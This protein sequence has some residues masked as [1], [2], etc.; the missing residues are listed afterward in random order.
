MVQQIEDDL[1]NEF[2]EE[3]T[4]V[5]K[6][7]N[8]KVLFPKDCDHKEF[9][10]LF[11][12]TKFPEGA[13]N[14]ILEKNFAV[15]IM[16]NKLDIKIIRE[17]YKS[18]NWSVG[19]LLGWLRKVESGEIVEYNVGELINW[20]KDVSED[21]TLMLCDKADIQEPEKLNYNLIWDKE[22]AGFKEEKKD[23]IIE[24]YIPRRSVGVWTGKRGTF[25][26]FLT[27]SALYSIGSETPFLGTFPT[28]RCNIL[29]LDKENG[30]SIMKDRVKMIK[31][32]LGCDDI[33][34]A[35]IFFSNIKIDRPT[36]FDI[37]ENL[38]N[39]NKIDLLVV[40]TYRRAIRFD[41]NDAG[42]VSHLFVDYLRPLAEKYDCTIV[43]IHHDRKGGGEGDEM[44][45]IRGSSDLANYCDF[46]FRNE[47]NGNNLILKQLKMRAAPEQEPVSINIDTDEV[48]YIT[49]KSTGKYVKPTTEQKAIDLML[50]WFNENNLSDFTSNMALG[51]MTENGIK[52]R[53]FY[54]SISTMKQMGLIKASVQKGSY[55][56]IIKS[57]EGSE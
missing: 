21:L 12:S 32:G 3:L 43:L 29:Y 36:D 35:Y 6:V 39:E 50:E 31:T 14:L 55:E 30:A 22:L 9:W 57:E 42:A 15:W 10:D 33:D 48:N 41:E 27:L 46:I 34:L 19:G 5:D 52:R 20:S 8:R 23:W 37:I 17:K 51:L 44:D 28:K 38:I 4:K 18:Q 40:D 54:N 7:K 13:I 45:N 53:T 56:V 1:W 47:R 26:T 49:F 2:Q 16:Q 24:K 25:K 11:L